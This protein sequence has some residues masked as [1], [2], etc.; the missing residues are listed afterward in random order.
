MY[1]QKIPQSIQDY[2]FEIRNVI[3]KRQ[4]TFR[5]IFDAIIA[6]RIANPNDLWNEESM[7]N[8]H[9]EFD[10]MS[11]AFALFLTDTPVLPGIQIAHG[12]IDPLQKLVLLRWHGSPHNKSD[13][14]SIF[15]SKFHACAQILL[16]IEWNIVQDLSLEDFGQLKPDFSQ[17]IDF[18][19]PH[20][21][22]KHAHELMKSMIRVGSSSWYEHIRPM[23]SKYVAEVQEKREYE[24]KILKQKQEMHMFYQQLIIELE[25]LQNQPPSE[26]EPHHKYYRFGSKQRCYSNEYFPNVWYWPRKNSLPSQGYTPLG[27]DD[28][29]SD[30][31]FVSFYKHAQPISKEEYNKWVSESQYEDRKEEEFEYFH[32]C[33]PGDEDDD[34]RE[35]KF[36][37]TALKRKEEAADLLRYLKQKYPP[38][39]E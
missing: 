3:Q 27:V 31:G 34:Y 12:F 5:E 29:I 28:V 11:S 24:E 20:P 18:N 32:S 23:L 37:W 39:S 19:L 30:E 6:R 2:F 21:F 36:S 17:S 13:D 33:Y 25:A 1:Q 35:Y 22:L 9:L 8:V 15:S 26:T 7:K 4:M 38:K 16:D 14:D 10:L